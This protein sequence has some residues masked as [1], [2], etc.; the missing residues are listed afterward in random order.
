M[1][2]YLNKIREPEIMS[3]HYRVLN[4]ILII[5]L[6]IF[7]GIISKMFDETASNLLPPFIEML[8][9]RN[10]FSRIGIW[11]FLA[12]AISI[13]S[14]TPLRAA[15]NVFLF[16]VGMVSSYYMYTALI[17]GFFPRTYMMIWIVLT[18]I[19]PFLA[20]FCWYAKGEG[21]IPII[22]SA[23]IFT[24]ISRQTFTFGYWYFEVRHF[25]EL[26]L[27]IGTLFILFKS[28]NQIIKVVLIG[29]LIYFLTAPLHL[30]WGML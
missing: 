25:L 14:K 4:S 20:F 15:T 7:L 28:F 10:F 1:L 18:L 21:F 5:L 27:W 13:N 26:I 29:A 24:F 8:D 22:I 23:S 11:I 19:S 3:N 2:N 9:L 6:G 30:F 12:V 16:F 17:A